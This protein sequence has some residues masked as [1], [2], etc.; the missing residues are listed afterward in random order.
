MCDIRLH[1]LDFPGRCLEVIRSDRLWSLAFEDLVKYIL[2][3]LLILDACR[4]V[5]TVETVEL[6]V[7]VCINLNRSNQHQIDSY[8]HATNIAF[9]SFEH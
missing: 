7:K 3:P 2:Y 4:C 1:L 9:P 5:P 8:L 6:V